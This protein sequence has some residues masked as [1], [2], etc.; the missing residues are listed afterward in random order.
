MESS[1]FIHSLIHT[2]FIILGVATE[3]KIMSFKRTQA[4]SHGVLQTSEIKVVGE[5]KDIDKI[6]S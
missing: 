6:M 3:D 2:I 1:F 4:Y 5:E